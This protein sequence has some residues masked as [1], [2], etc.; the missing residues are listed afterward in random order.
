MQNRTD[1]FIKNDKFPYTT[2]SKGVLYEK[3]VRAYCRRRG[4]QILSRNL[5]LSGGEI[6][7][8]AWDQTKN[9][10]II[11]EVRGRKQ[12]KYAPSKFLSRSKVERLKKMAMILV[13]QKKCSVRIYLLE[14]IGN[15][16]AVYLQWGIE[17]FPEKLGLVLRD[18]E[19]T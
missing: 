2:K 6:D 19:V 16:P 9:T 5:R 3:C 1:E 17:Y 18:F 7:C 8:L 10:L 12:Q 15:L 11:I 14:V 4:F 13:K